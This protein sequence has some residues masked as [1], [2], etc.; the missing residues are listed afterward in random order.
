MKRHH[1]KNWLIQVEKELYMF[2][3]NFLS[4]FYVRRKKSGKMIAYLMSFPRN[5]NGL[6]FKM[7]EE[8]PENDIIIFYEVRCSDEAQRMSEKGFQIQSLET[9]FYFFR[10]ALFKLCQ[11]DILICDNYYAF[12]GAIQLRKSCKVI[13]LWHANGAIKC[14]GWQDQQTKKRSWLDQRRFTKVYQRFDEYI[15]GSKRMGAV[16]Q[17]SYHAKP[18]QMQYLGYPRTDI[19]FDKEQIERR[20]YKLQEKY[21]ELAGKKIILY[22]PTYRLKEEQELI[23]LTKLA[24]KFSQEYVLVIKAH[25]HTVQKFAGNQEHSF[26]FSALSDYPIEEILPITDCLITDY[27]SL[28]FDYSLV[29]PTGKIIFYW[30]DFLFQSSQIGIQSDF[31][32]WNPGTIV[33]SMEQLVLAIDEPHIEN[34]EK[35][36]LEWNEFNDGHAAA[37]F[38]RHIKIVLA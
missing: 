4:F 35:F 26:Y 9:S 38:I 13:Q 30:Y 1:K 23:D 36:N 14:F 5:D 7:M 11:A 22:A 37:R 6:L 10:I 19:F 15:V 24:E 28:P 12:L 16:F 31:P 2:L 25:P 3:V 21:P 29:R 32:E 33:Y 34:F 20:K 27:S 18:E 8:F 17:R